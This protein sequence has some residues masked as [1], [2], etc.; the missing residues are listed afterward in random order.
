MQPTHPFRLLARSTTIFVRRPTRALSIIGIGAALAVGPLV[1]VLTPLAHAQSSASVLGSALPSLSPLVEKVLPAVVNISVTQRAGAAGTDGMDDDEGPGSGSGNPNSPFDELLRR[2]FEQQQN[3]G[4]RT[5]PNQ[6]ARKVVSL[7]SGFIIDPSGY[8]VTNNHVAGDAETVTVIFQDDSRHPAKLIGRD[9]RTD[10]ALLK[11]DAPKPLPYVELGDSDGAKVGDW[12]IAVGNPFGLGGTVTAGIVS[13]RGRVI[14]ESSYDDFMQIDASINRGNS[15]GP[16]FDLSGHVIGI[17]TAIYSPN[18][19][20]VGIGFAIPANQAKAVL[21]Q[22][23]KNGKVERG[24]LGVNIQ[25]VTPEIAGS[26]GL[27]TDHPAGALVSNVTENGPSAKAGIR[28]GDVIQKFN[29]KPVDKMR[30]LPRLVAETPVGSKVDVTLWRKNAIQTVQATLGQLP[31]ETKV[32][33]VEKPDPTP[34]IENASSLGLTLS[35]LN[36][37]IRRRLNIP[38]EV[39][40]VLVSRVRDGSAAAERGIQAGDV[41]IAVN[42]Q[43]VSK[44]DEVSDRVRDAQNNN[45]RGVLLLINRGGNNIYVAVTPKEKEG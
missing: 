35:G 29:G 14:G 34:P 18:G 7:G 10:L 16:T 25:E 3:R 2:F 37:D 20:S 33:S 31:D 38:K 39:K 45:R 21:A 42:E 27:D 36:P 1:P 6:P 8:V 22:L 15:G 28:N 41:I 17:N 4:G 9:K 19:G 44:P 11:I 32:A 23:R 5:V 30:D 13:A 12:V 24:W 43:S 40:G 26:L